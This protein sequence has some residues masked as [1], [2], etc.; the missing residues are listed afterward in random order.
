MLAD[1]TPVF[2]AVEGDPDEVVLR[3]LV[4]EAGGRVEAVYGKT[5]KADLLRQLKAYNHAAIYAPWVV[6]VDLDRSAECPPPVLV[7]WLPHPAPLMCFRIVVRA[8]EAW[9]MADRD[10]MAAFLGVP[11][12]RVPDD[13]ECLENPKEAMVSLASRSRSRAIRE[14][15]VPRPGSGRSVGPAYTSRLMEFAAIHWRPDV[16][17]ERAASLQRSRARLETLL[18]GPALPP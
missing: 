2:T 7:E 13:P 10:Q 9:L 1:V 12:H 14:D 18:R 4:H 8:I 3:R 11:Y 6:L 5:G 17:A 16:A 15:M